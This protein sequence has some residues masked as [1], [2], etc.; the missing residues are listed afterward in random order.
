MYLCRM[1]TDKALKDIGDAVGG[2]NHST[3]IS[4]IKRVEERLDSEPELEDTIEV[5]KKKI[6][7]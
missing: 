7:G 5:I 4:G 1:L 2:K 3:V 6:G